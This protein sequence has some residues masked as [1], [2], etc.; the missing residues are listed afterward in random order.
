MQSDSQIA[1]RS[2]LWRAATYII[3]P[4]FLGVIATIS[5]PEVQDVK[6]TRV[7]VGGAPEKQVGFRLVSQL[8]Y[9]T[10][11][12]KKIILGMFDRNVSYV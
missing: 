2:A 9:I 4:L 12:S 5:M 3:C 10:E 1:R 7:Q 8:R 6:R 11:K